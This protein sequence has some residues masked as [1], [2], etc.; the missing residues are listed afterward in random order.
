MFVPPDDLAALG[1]A[2]ETLIADPA[3]RRTFGELAQR[4]ARRF[5][6]RAM[7]RATR[8]VYAKLTDPRGPALAPSPATTTTP[9]GADTCAL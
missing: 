6:L 4:R 2:L 5:S 3:A 8:E 9:N 7:C 1:R